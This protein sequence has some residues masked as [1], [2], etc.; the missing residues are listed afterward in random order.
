MWNRIKAVEEKDKYLL[1]WYAKL[2]QSKKKKKEV[3]KDTCDY[4]PVIYS[5]SPILYLLQTWHPLLGTNGLL[6]LEPFSSFLFVER[7]TG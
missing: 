7:R 5:Y 4:D 1:H 2:T 6:L 3:G